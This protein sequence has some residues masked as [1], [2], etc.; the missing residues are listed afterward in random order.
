MIAF[1]SCRLNHHI[2]REK[3]S[4]P[5][6]LTT[7]FSS[8]LHTK[9]LIELRPFADESPRKKSE[10]M[11][12]LSTSLLIKEPLFTPGSVYDKES[13]QVHIFSQRRVV[14][15]LL[16]AAPSSKF[17]SQR[18]GA[19]GQSLDRSSPVRGKSNE[20][21]SCSLAHQ[22]GGSLTYKSFICIT[23]LQFSEKK[24]DSVVVHSSCLVIQGLSLA[25]WMWVL[26]QWT[27]LCILVHIGNTEERNQK[28]FLLQMKVWCLQDHSWLV[29]V[30]KRCL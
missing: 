21:L 3:C 28:V 23:P 25:C 8:K 18:H 1:P 13:S 15:L 7:Q 19:R 12:C 14:F 10:S 5:S 27:S 11:P 2:R 6:T 17:P 29:D 9:H 22:Q 30:G 24:Q 4:K 16:N 26:G 20:S